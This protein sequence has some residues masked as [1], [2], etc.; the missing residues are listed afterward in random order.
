[1]TEALLVLEVWTLRP[2]WLAG[3]RTSSHQIPPWS[4]FGACE[5]ALRLLIGRTG[6]LFVFAPSMLNLK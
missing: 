3:T 1:M 4:D 2:G 5:G 6:M